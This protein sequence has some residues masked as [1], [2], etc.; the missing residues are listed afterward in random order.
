MKILCLV[1]AAMISQSYSTSV[2]SRDESE[3]PKIGLALS[4]GGAR[5]GAHVGVLKALEELRVPVDYI[6]GTSMGAIIGGFYAAGYDADEIEQLL[7]DTDWN[8][9]LSDQ[10]ARRDRTMRKKELES[11][12]LIPYRLGYN[13]GRLQAA[14]GAIEGQHLDQIFQRILLPVVNTRDFDRLAIPFRAVATDLVTGEEV[15]LRRGSLADA[16]RASMSVPGVFAPVRIDD[17]LLVDGG[18]ANNLPVNVVRAMGADIV[19]AVDVSTP[20]LAEDQITSVLSI[21]EQLTN[22]L[23]RRST[24]RQ[25]AS[26]RPQDVL[27][28]PELG[29]FSSADFEQ[30]AQV[31]PAGHEAAMKKRDSLAALPG[32]GA[33][34]PVEPL[35]LDAS[36]Y[37]VSFV[38]IRNNSVLNDALIRSRLAV[39]PGQQFDAQELD[40]SMDRIYGLDVFQS[41][42]YD[43]VENAQG[44]QGVRVTA[45]ARTWGP[46]YLQFGLELSNDFSGSSDFKLGAGYTR[47]ALNALGGELRVIASLGREDEL[48][49]D[50]YQPIDLEARWFVN[51]GV[52][53][54][55]Q[56]YSLWLDERRAAEL[57]IGGWRTAFGIGRN[58]GTT[59]QLRLDYQFGRAESSVLTGT[60]P[61]LDTDDRI[62]I[63]EVVLSH[64]HDSLD[65]LYFPTRG[66]TQKV[67][68]RYADENIGAAAD[69][70]Q[71]G[72]AGSWV[73]S[74]GRNTGLLN[75]EFGYS[76]DDAA[77]LERWFQ[78]G[79][80]GRLSGL[81]PDQLSGR[82]V[83][84]TSVAYYR[85]LNDIR[86]LPVYAGVTLEAGNTWY[87][88]DDVGFDDLRYSGSV[89]IGAESPLGPL[90]FALGYSDS[91]DG[92]VYF[93]LGNPFQPNSLD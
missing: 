45:D 7:R 18:M 69:Y 20:F 13:S 89:F 48:R 4:G 77:P 14:L 39:Q 29:D 60:L 12:F 78:L 71:A 21:T 73:F 40:R 24:E 19:I 57:E 80:L 76:F 36:D 32:A 58:F 61:F 50:Y 17:H 6:A 3:R 70:Q 52:R 10:P 1:L 42:T 72:F 85:R 75:Y 33:A 25:I 66:S 47:N 9:A 44:E 91:G 26:L 43:L 15:V 31:V 55:R 51:P 49:F 79:G 92:A 34:Q 68:Y 41:V 64:L 54:M 5:G 53:W 11:D 74:R 81:A 46:N 22:F 82:Q 28:L 62:D 8:E 87:F 38:E 63:G 65:S 86:F 88:S 2:V 23:T 35:A 84:L 37:L 30:A 59:G 90:Y 83:A 93:Y 67:F 56:N 27:I 16:L